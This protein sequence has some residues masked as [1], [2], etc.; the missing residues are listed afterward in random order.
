MS[1]ADDLKEYRKEHKEQSKKLNALLRELKKTDNSRER[2]VIL[3]KLEKK[4]KDLRETN[5]KIA[6]IL[7]NIFR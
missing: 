5:Q 6:A 4:L 3:E 7:N 1:M 2:S